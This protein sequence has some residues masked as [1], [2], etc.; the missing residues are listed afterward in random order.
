MAG[1]IFLKDV[2]S[3]TKDGRDFWM[4]IGSIVPQIPPLWI[5]GRVYS[6]ISEVLSDGK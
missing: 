3:A 1:W 4:T 5:G 6:M 2:Y